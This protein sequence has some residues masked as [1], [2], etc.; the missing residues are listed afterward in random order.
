MNVLAKPP[1][2]MPSGPSVPPHSSSSSRSTKVPAFTGNLSLGSSPIKSTNGQLIVVAEP[3]PSFIE[4]YDRIRE[5]YYRHG[6]K[7]LTKF[8]LD[9]LE[10]YETST[11][12]KLHY[13]NRQRKRLQEVG[14]CPMMTEYGPVVVVSQDD[15]SIL[16]IGGNHG[17]GGTSKPK[18][19]AGRKGHGSPLKAERHH[20][21]PANEEE[22]RQ[23][24]EQF[25]RSM[26]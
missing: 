22:S 12:M 14:I 16:K 6:S 15:D 26:L 23:R 1:L 3:L 2:S 19:R 10:R 8:L 20:T 18:S 5:W 25:F 13:L 11:V 21:P 9:Y 17:V 24:Y 4:E 7:P